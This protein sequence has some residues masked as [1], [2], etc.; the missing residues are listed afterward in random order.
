M[1]E[2]FAVLAMLGLLS[3]SSLSA[4]E[5]LF[6]AGEVNL[7]GFGNWV[8]KQEDNWGG[9]VGFNYF[10][11]KYIGLGGSTHWENFDG[12]FI[13]NAAGEGYLRMPLQRLPLAPYGVGTGG[14]S[15]ENEEWFYGVG[16]GAEWRFTREFGIFSDI[17]WLWKE[18]GDRDG[19]SVRVGIRLGM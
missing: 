1:K 8:D 4:Q 19:L 7:I 5:D 11:S 17:Q 18:S 2:R 9:G 13:D 12:A 10:F 6:R 16:G 15:W 3:L 14:Y